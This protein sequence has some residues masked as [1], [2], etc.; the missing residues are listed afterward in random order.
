MHPAA[1]GGSWKDF[2]FGYTALLLLLLT[3][4]HEHQQPGAEAAT[5]DYSIQELLTKSFPH[6]ISEDIYLDPCKAGKEELSE[7]MEQKKLS[8]THT[9]KTTSPEEL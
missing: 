7:F 8:H 5:V 6:R 2:P 3:G 4:F 9:H 1:T